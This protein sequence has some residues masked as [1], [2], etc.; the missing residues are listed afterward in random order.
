MDSY[1]ILAWIP[2]GFKRDPECILYG[3]DTQ[4]IAGFFMD[5]LRTM[6]AF[7]M[8]SIAILNALC[9]DF[10][11]MPCEIYVWILNGLQC[12][13][14]YILHGVHSLISMDSECIPQ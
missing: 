10:T 11:W 14:E 3:F 9:M 1:G 12:H 2:I 7:C 13:S 6:N 8:N 5:D 4:Y